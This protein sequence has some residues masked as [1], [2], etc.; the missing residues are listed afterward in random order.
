MIRIICINF[1]LLIT[2]ST[3]GQTHL[4]YVLPPDWQIPGNGVL[5]ACI[6]L[7]NFKN[8]RFQPTVGLKDFSSDFDRAVVKCAKAFSTGQKLLGITPEGQKFKATVNSIDPEASNDLGVFMLKIN[9]PPGHI[10][11]NGALLMTSAIPLRNM[12]RRTERLDPAVESLLRLRA[13]KLWNHHLPERSNDERPS[14][15]TLEPPIVE[16]VKELPGVIVVRFP[17]DIVEDNLNGDGRIDH[18]DRGQM[19]FIYSTIDKRVIREEFGH[20]EWA[21]ASTV[22]TIKPWMYF[23]VGVGDSVFFIG[24]NTSGWE[25]E[26]AA[27]FDLKTGREILSC[28]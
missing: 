9:L 21:S 2:T 20:P 5:S 17:M 7:G 24:E 1:A 15:F 12:H 16:S 23:K 4:A 13:Q 3:F 26:E 8:E 28:W 14:R 27:L 25:S 6:F 19:F 18:D 22:R 10:L 11:N